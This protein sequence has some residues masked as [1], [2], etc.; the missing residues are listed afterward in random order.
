MLQSWVN[1]ITAHKENGRAIKKNC[2]KLDASIMLVL[3]KE[4]SNHNLSVETSI[5]DVKYLRWT[6][7]LSKS[8]SKLC[9][10]GIGSNSCREKRNKF[11]KLYKVFWVKRDTALKTLWPPIITRPSNFKA[12]HATNASLT[13][14]VVRIWSLVRPSKS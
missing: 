14:S 7:W 6:F 9:S 3:I 5:A 11:K 8:F 13:C 4:K 10:I 1:H 12:W 2:I